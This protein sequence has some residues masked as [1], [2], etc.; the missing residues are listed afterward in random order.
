[1]ICVVLFF[2]DAQQMIGNRK[3]ILARS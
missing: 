1:L 2:G 3:S